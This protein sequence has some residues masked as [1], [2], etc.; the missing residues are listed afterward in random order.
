MAAPVRTPRES[1]VEAGLLAL[2]AGGPD[3]VRV[4]AL[5]KALGVTKGGFYWHFT[6][7]DALLEAM[8]DT[9]E[10]RLVDQAVTT[11]DAGGGDARARLR[12]LFRFAGS[13][14]GLLDLE[15]TVRDWARR[16]P[17]VA[18]RVRR[19]DDRRM[20]YLRPLF[21]EFCDGPADVEGRCLL[22][23]TLFV[24]SP[25]VGASHGR[26]TRSQAETAA[27]RHLLR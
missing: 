1:W 6:D 21:A 26:R 16:S 17:S 9:W 13:N 5:A 4:E 3:A 22:V 10:T 24:G 15:L 23:L 11:A 7:R 25:G 18:T 12:R 2:S 14:P 8:L 19:V 20:A 27:V